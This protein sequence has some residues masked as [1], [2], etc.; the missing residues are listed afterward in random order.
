MAS[1]DLGSDVDNC[2]I[3]T[4]IVQVAKRGSLGEIGLQTKNLACTGQQLIPDPLVMRPLKSYAIRW[5]WDQRVP[6]SEG[7]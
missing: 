5:I 1:L 6:N 3:L 2:G 4:A 7:A